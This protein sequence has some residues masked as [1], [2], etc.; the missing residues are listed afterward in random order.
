MSTARATLD[1]RTVDPFP[2][3]DQEIERLQ[4]FLHGLDESGWSAPSLCAAWSVKD[5]AAH[6]ASIEVYNE[7]CLE[8]KLRVL[9]FSGNPDDWNEQGVAERRRMKYEEVLA[10]WER[11]QRRIRDKWGR[12][13][14]DSTIQTSAGPYPLRLQVWHHAMEYATHADDIEVPVPA[15]EREARLGWRTAQRAS[16]S[17]WTRSRRVWA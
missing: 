10:E 4:S 17:L 16:A 7:A 15:N 3:Y 9:H 12:I 13:G 2:A 8:G 1:P 6:L 5:V 14:L 11:R